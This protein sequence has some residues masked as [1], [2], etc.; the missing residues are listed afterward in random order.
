MAA[1]DVA[2]VEPL[3]PEDVHHGQAA[4]VQHLDQFQASPVNRN[5]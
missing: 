1:A 4:L 2:E 3:L 5:I